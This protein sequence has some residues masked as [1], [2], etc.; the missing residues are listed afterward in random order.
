MAKALPQG[1]PVHRRAL[2]GL[3]DADG[4][5]WAS[6]KAF[7]WLLVIIMA[8]GY[9]PDRAYYFVVSRTIDLGIMFWSP[10]NLCPPENGTNMPCP[11]PGGAVV[12]WQAAPANV[13]LPQPRTNGVAAQIGANLLYIG[14]TVG[15]ADGAPAATTY[16]TTVV[17]GNFGAWAEGPALPEAR[18]DAALANLS[19]TAYLIGGVGPDGEPTDTVWSIGLN[20]DT[21]ELGTWTEVKLSETEAL[22]LPEA[23]SG[24]SAVAVTDGIVV[25]GGRDA[26]GNPTATVWKSTLDDDGALSEFREQPS[27]AYPVA[28]ASIALEGTFLWLYGG[29]DAN[30]PV[31]GVQRAQFGELA[32]EEAGHGAVATPTPAPSGTP[33]TGDAVH[34]WKVDPAVNLP[35]ARTGA[36]GFAANGALYVVGGSDGTTLRRELYWA[37]PDATGALPAGWRHLDP[38]D[39]P[40]GVENAAAVT[41]GSTVFLLGGDGESGAGT[42]TLRASLAPE[43]PF[44]QLGL[45]GVVVPALKIGGEIGQQLGY[46]AAAGVG[47]GN[48]VILIAIGWAF[49]HRQQI[50]GWLERR[51]IAKEAKAPPEP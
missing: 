18:S 8:L 28:D 10:V 41:S 1:R 43:E 9:I 44:F 48:F 4:W 51:R 50:R 23:R 7:I 45:V 14:G 2:F 39:L 32:V 37:V 47:T 16:V 21:S 30:G 6:T 15:T 19:G 26:D 46:L 34:E 40:A 35:A 33:D 27:L 5:G 24:A 17:S 13:A 25:A 12:P 36:S 29:S 20:P 3:F 11:V 49:N 31:G 22:T 42:V 38:T